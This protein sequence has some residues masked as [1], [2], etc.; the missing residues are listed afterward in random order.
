ME[1]TA[2]SIARTYSDRVYPDPWE[3]VED[4]QRV[5]AYAAEH[6]NAGRHSRTPVPLPSRQM[7]APNRAGTD[8]GKPQQKYNLC[9]ADK[10]VQGAH[11]RWIP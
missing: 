11:V 9:L 8:T 7:S 6:P 1:P 10:L 2:R 4:Y 3:K 5:Q